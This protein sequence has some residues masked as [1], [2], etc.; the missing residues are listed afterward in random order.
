M[1]YLR[2][3]KNLFNINL[4]GNPCSKEDNY[5]LFIAAFFPDLKFLDYTLL[6]ENTVSISAVFLIK[7]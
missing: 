5:T 3:F 2:K 4:F 1:L 7:H 6:D